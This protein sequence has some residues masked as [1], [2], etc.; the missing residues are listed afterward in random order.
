MDLA[1]RKV[2]NGESLLMIH[3]WGMNSAVWDPIA[4]KLQEDYE[5]ILIDLPGMGFSHEI[6]PLNLERIVSEI[7]NLIPDSVNVCG[8]SM[9]GLVAMRL[10]LSKKVKR[11]ILTGSSPRFVNNQDEKWGNGI[12]ECVFRKF[13]EQMRTDY[14]DTLFK[15]LTLQ[16]M[17]AKDARQIIRVLRKSFEERPIPNENGLMSALDILLNNDLRDD[18][19]T[20]ACPMLLIHG[21]RDTLAPKEA[22]LWMK[23]NARAST[24][25]CLIPGASHAPFLSHADKFIELTKQF[26]A[27][28]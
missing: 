27:Q 25:L 7:T 2:G 15:F 20:I 17:G 3:G 9:G 11:L 8:W 14:H 5:L 23:E 24:D 28:A 22:A 13:A 12:N 1:Y 6:H 4:E 21:E 18:F 26:L 16:C 19:V 10:A